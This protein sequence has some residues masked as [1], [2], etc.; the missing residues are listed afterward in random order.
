MGPEAAQDGVSRLQPLPALGTRSLSGG[1]QPPGLGHS[2]GAG[3]LGPGWPCGPGQVHR[4]GPTRA[5]DRVKWGG[6]AGWGAAE[7]RSSTSISS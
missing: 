2:A 4:S 3:A 1:R 6:R 5:M 7:G